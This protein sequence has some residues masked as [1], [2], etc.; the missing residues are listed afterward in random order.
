VMKRFLQVLTALAA[1][2]ALA[3]CGGKAASDA[4]TS[5]GGMMENAA[6]TAAGTPAA[7]Q[8]GAGSQTPMD[9]G[10]VQ[11]VW[12]NLKTMKYHEPND[13]YYG[14]TKHGEYMCPAQARKAGYTPAGGGERHHHS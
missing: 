5:A 8:I 1:A 11:P 6:N 3:A 7:T 9:C 10:A 4:N 14:K 12:V 13:P 2:A